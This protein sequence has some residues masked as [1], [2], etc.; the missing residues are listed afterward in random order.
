MSGT[1]ECAE[2]KRGD[3]ATLGPEGIN[4]P[5]DSVITARIPRKNKSPWAAERQCGQISPYWC[6]EFR[7]SSTITARVKV[8]RTWN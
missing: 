2:E 7:T 1:R 3:L 8:P 5:G 6:Q 4:W